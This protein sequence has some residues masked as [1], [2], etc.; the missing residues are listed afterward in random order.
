MKTTPQPGMQP[1][2]DHMTTQFI[3]T[4]GMESM[5]PKERPQEPVPNT[6]KLV[7]MA[8]QH[9][10]RAKLKP[11]DTGLKPSEL[12]ERLG[13]EKRRVSW[14]VSLMRRSGIPVKSQKVEEK[15]RLW[16]NPE[17]VEQLLVR[18]PFVR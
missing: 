3:E 11:E 13:I 9:L 6:T 5:M 7:V 18:D 14:L 10:C 1:H 4:Q 2:P 8:M 16:L 17:D 12:A 15:T